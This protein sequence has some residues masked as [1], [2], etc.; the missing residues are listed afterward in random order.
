M[1]FIN[2]LKERGIIMSEEEKN[3]YYNEIVSLLRQKNEPITSISTK[4]DKE[5]YSKIY[6]LYH[7]F[8]PKKSENSY[9]Y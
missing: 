5:Y 8:S 4:L 7:S 3:N 6:E 9:F 2:K 1:Y